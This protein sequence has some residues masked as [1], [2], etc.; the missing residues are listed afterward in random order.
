MFPDLP[1]KFIARVNK[2]ETWDCTDQINEE[3]FC[4]EGIR[5]KSVE[6]KD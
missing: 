4:Q 6:I 2:A 3:K 1:L 5:C